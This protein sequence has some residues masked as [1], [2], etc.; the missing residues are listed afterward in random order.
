MLP[1]LRYMLR[2]IGPDITTSDAEG[3]AAKSLVSSKVFRRADLLCKASDLGG[4][5]TDAEQED[6]DK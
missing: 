5:M 2:C 1:Y 6:G 3:D 4:L